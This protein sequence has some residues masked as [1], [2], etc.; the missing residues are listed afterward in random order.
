M[1]VDSKYHD[2]LMQFIT[3]KRTADESI[4]ELSN[5]MKTPVRDREIEKKLLQ[6]MDDA[7]NIAN[8]F[9]IELEKVQLDK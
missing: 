3:A 7:H 1:I 5:F 9:W 4:S 8:G 2:L 6:Q